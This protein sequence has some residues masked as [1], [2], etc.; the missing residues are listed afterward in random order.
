MELKRKLFGRHELHDIVMALLLGAVFTLLV[1][2]F[3]D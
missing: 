1:L 3:S 2:I